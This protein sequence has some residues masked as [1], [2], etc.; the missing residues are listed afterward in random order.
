MFRASGYEWPVWAPGSTGPRLGRYPVRA[1]EDAARGREPS[2][3]APAPPG[4]HTGQISYFTRPDATD[5]SISQE[6]P[7]G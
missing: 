5:E 2:A 1:R 3:R 6:A 7:M 4:A